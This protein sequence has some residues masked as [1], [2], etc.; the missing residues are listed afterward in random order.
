MANTTLDTTLER[1]VATDNTPAP[2][3][4][5]KCNTSAPVT[6]G[7]KRTIVEDRF[8]KV[9][10]LLN[11]IA[12]KHGFTFRVE[13]PVLSEEKVRELFSKEFFLHENE[14][15]SAFRLLK[16]NGGK[17]I[18]NGVLGVQ[19]GKSNIAILYIVLTC[20]VEFLCI[21]TMTSYVYIMPQDKSIE[22]LA[23]AS[24]YAMIPYLSLITF[25]MD[26]K[27]S[28]FFMLMRE[29]YGGQYFEDHIIAMTSGKIVKQ[30]IQSRI[31]D[32]RSKGQPCL[33]VWDEFHYADNKRGI[34]EDTIWNYFVMTLRGE[35]KVCVISATSYLTIAVNKGQPHAIEIVRLKHAPTYVGYNFLHGEVIDPEVPVVTPKH[36]SFE[37]LQDKLMLD[38]IPISPG[39]LAGNDKHQDYLSSFGIYSPED[40][41]TCFCSQLLEFYKFLAEDYK[42]RYYNKS[43]AVGALARI[44]CDNAVCELVCKEI[45]SQDMSISVL[46]YFDDAKYLEIIRQVNECHANNMP[47]IIV[48][49]QRAR[50][51][52]RFPC[53]VG[54]FLD[55]TKKYST[56]TSGGQGC[57]ARAA[58]NEGKIRHV[59]VSQDNFEWLEDYVRNLGLTNKKPHLRVKFVSNGHRPKCR[60]KYRAFESH[61]ATSK[62][63]LDYFKVQLAGAIRDNMAK[64]Q[65]NAKAKTR[66]V[67]VNDTL[68]EGCLDEM[69]QVYGVQFLRI[70]QIPEWCADKKG[71]PKENKY[72]LLHKNGKVFFSI[73]DNEKRKGRKEKK[74]SL[75]GDAG[76]RG[77]NSRGFQPQVY[78]D[79]NNGLVGIV[80]PL[81]KENIIEIRVNDNIAVDSQSLWHTLTPV[82]PVTPEEGA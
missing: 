30:K 60:E 47:F 55:C 61:D 19:G 24:W 68:Y 13:M 82:T 28:S 51:S 12:K 45:E 36:W 70:G 38:K 49:S 11:K 74:E 40:Y 34:A 79:K 10:A 69:D 27:T 3:T 2:V 77:T 46:R 56:A 53:S 78:I 9:T 66:G 48:V 39:I 58:N 41:K 20:C 18:I 73:R 81:V 80:M 14:I 65:K 50:M 43:V 1:L 7:Y 37:M 71:T 75:L 57:A 52:N 5:K 23:K 26:K 4:D 8:A 42:S 62:P 33:V 16:K 44:M 17:K 35:E 54:V 6:E 25:S 64:L 29:M 15:E 32:A 21:G 72:K 22:A 63:L 59:V 67:W 76:M 31:A